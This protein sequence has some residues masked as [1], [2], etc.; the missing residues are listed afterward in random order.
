[1][2]ESIRKTA[3]SFSV[4]KKNFNKFEQNDTASQRQICEAFLL[5]TCYFEVQV[6]FSRVRQKGALML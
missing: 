1:M 6:G 5:G 4:L 2:I 3:A